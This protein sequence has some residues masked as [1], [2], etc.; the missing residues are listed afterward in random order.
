M[1]ECCRNK[2]TPY[3]GTCGSD[4]EAKS[5]AGLKKYLES[6]LHSARGRLARWMES[7]DIG[8]EK[9]KQ[10]I[11]RSTDSIIQLDS[12]IAEIDKVTAK[13]NTEARAD[14]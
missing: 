12:W 4:L 14:A 1:M 13:A 11:V 3:C 9:V 7:D 5:L 2:T 6:R 10:G 8:E